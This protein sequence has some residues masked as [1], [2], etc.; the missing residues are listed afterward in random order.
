MNVTNT[1]STAPTGATASVNPTCPSQATTLSATGG[2]LGTGAAWN[3]YTGSCG[4]IFVS[5][6][7]PSVSPASTTTYY[8]RAVGTC[9]TT[10][11]A[12]VTVTVNTIPTGVTASASPNP[13]CA[14]ATLTLT[15]GATGATT[16]SWTGPNAFTSALQSPAIAG[17][18]TAGAGIYTLTASNSCGAATAV[19]TA[20]VTIITAPAPPTILGPIAVAVSPCSSV[21][22]SCGNIGTVNYTASSPGATS[23]TWTSVCSDYLCGDNSITEICFGGCVDGVYVVSATASNAC[24]TSSPGSLSVTKTGG[25]CPCP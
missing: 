3:W 13:I 10:A 6:G 14:G 17:I 15:G 12:S 20:S 5:T 16:W 22:G 25:F 8:V 18:T 2:S 11:C 24:G 7:S 4:G 1:N 21:P 9:N 19:S 23:Y